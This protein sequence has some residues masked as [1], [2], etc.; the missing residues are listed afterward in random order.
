M[1][2]NDIGSRKGSAQAALGLR[3]LLYRSQEVVLAEAHPGVQIADAHVGGKCVH[4]CGP[5]GL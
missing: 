2:G 4:E 5:Q 1:R 3:F